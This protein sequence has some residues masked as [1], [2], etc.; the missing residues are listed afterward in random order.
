[1][2]NSHLP[3]KEPI[4]EVFCSKVLSGVTGK[5]EDS[6]LMTCALPT[7]CKPQAG[8]RFPRIRA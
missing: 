8:Q 3:L 4:L 6:L 7:R 1:M 5:P 2:S